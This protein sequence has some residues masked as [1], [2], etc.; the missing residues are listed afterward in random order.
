[1][2]EPRATA[3]FDFIVDA[4]KLD[5][6]VAGLTKIFGRLDARDIGAAVQ[7]KAIDIDLIRSSDHPLF[8]AAL[9]RLRRGQ[10]AR[11]VIVLDEELAGVGR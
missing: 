1:M 3:D 4:A 6:I 7:L 11:S 10:G 2:T 5:D 9:E 8:E